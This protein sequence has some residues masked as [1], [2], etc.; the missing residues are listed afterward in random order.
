MP[1]ILAADFPTGDKLE[2]WIDPQYLDPE[3][4]E[5]IQC[6]FEKNSSIALNDF[7]ILEKYHEVLAE[8]DHANWKPIGP[9]NRRHYST[10]GR[11]K[12]ENETG[13]IRQLNHFLR[14]QTM[15]HFLERL[16]GLSIV[17]SGIGEVRC[18]RNQDYTLVHDNE[19]Q[20][21][22][23]GL[24]LYFNV[25]DPNSTWEDSYGGY[26]TYMDSETELL[27]LP[28]QSNVLSLVYR[29]VGCMKFVKF[30]TSQAPCNHYDFQHTFVTD[31]CQEGGDGDNEDNPEGDVEDREEGDY[32]EEGD[33]E[34][35][36][37]GDDEEDQ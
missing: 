17:S 21:Q 5:A 24:D 2:F 7:L 19:F 30:L 26:V 20:H 14:S 28:P 6:H 33:V 29:D 31:A 36:E 18:F 10:L 23:F 9:A 8:L 12:P 37:E 15:V 16:T 35:R 3:A 1:S 27:A 11:W 13:L 32:E 22:L 25:Q 34:D 4:Q